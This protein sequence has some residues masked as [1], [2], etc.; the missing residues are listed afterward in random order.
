MMGGGVVI[1]AK[2]L[3]PRLVRPGIVSTVSN[4][5]LNLIG[6]VFFFQKWPSK[7]PKRIVSDAF[8][9]LLASH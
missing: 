2:F 9:L 6:R 4:F 1:L 3:S 5:F 7:S 8:F